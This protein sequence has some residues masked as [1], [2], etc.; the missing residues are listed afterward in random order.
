[1]FWMDLVRAIRSYNLDINFARNIIRR[2]LWRV[3]GQVEFGQLV[4]RA[5]RIS[6]NVMVLWLCYTICNLKSQ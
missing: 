4:D 1:M 2:C 3:I 6:K 5:E